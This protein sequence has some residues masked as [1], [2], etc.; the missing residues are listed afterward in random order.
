MTFAGE[1]NFISR[2]AALTGDSFGSMRF[3]TVL[4]DL[5]GTLIDQFNAIYRCH[6]YAMRKLGL[7]EPTFAQVRNAVGGGLDTA[8]ARLA[9]EEHVAALLP[10]FTEHWDATNLQ[11]AK[12]LPGATELLVALNS[13]G[14]RCAVLTN[15]RAAA[16]RQVCAYLQLTPLLAGVFGAQDTPWIKPDA[17]FTQ[18][19]LTALGSEAHTTCLVGDSPYDL[20]AAQNAGLEFFGVTTGT[21]NEAELRAAGAREV[22]PS[23]EALTPLLIA[24]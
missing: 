16:A 13:A 24:K 6:V 17:R 4:F 3:R 15:K 1:W 14:I 12:L 21:H 20:A 10:L 7:P 8:I 2:E 9:G 5:D 11:D 19:A 18:H 22:H 23:L